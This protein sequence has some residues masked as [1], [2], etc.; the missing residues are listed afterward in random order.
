MNTK[1]PI[2]S[3]SSTPKFQAQ[4][5]DY[6]SLDESPENV[7][8]KKKTRKVEKGSAKKKR[9]PLPEKG[10][11]LQA[12]KFKYESPEETKKN[13]R[14]TQSS[15]SEGYQTD[16]TVSTVM[17][18][19]SLSSDEGYEPPTLVERDL[20]LGQGNYQ[21][22]D[23]STI[24]RK[25]KRLQAMLKKIEEE[26]KQSVDNYKNVNLNKKK[27]KKKSKSFEKRDVYAVSGLSRIEFN[28]GQ[29]LKF[30]IEYMQ[31]RDVAYKLK[32]TIKNLKSPNNY[33]NVTEEDF[34]K[35]MKSILAEEIMLC[36]KYVTAK[37]N[38]MQIDLESDLVQ[39][40]F[41]SIVPSDDVIEQV[42]KYLMG[43]FEKLKNGS[44]IQQEQGGEASEVLPE[45][46]EDLIG[47]VSN[48]LENFKVENGGVTVDQFDE[49]KAS[50]ITGII[51][52]LKKWW[53]NQAKVTLALSG[54]AATL[55]AIASGIIA[56]VEGVQD[57]PI[58]I[59]IPWIF[60][61]GMTVLGA[62]IDFV[63]A[64]RR[65]RKKANKERNTQ[66]RELDVVPVNLNPYNLKGAMTS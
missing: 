40:N 55:A 22:K 65:K 2:E 17:E 42:R 60:F 53:P 25:K 24:Q 35:T 62:F 30:S 31:A 66:V 50:Q 8:L 5:I 23:P 12:R 15:L 14:P 13:K 59:A 32:K 41:Q 11:L 61:L 54:S 51:Y 43:V 3:P 9:I 20:E 44:G 18:D 63:L 57:N 1:L 16:E 7:K 28:Q 45:G 26:E 52:L 39:D 56:A 64:Q 6:P 33:I 48:A 47:E 36:S 34:L 27:R 38:N 19:V 37:M 58:Y 46:Y 21:K 10:K 4:S 49:E 29:I